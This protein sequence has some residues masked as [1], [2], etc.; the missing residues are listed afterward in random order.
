M[1]LYPSWMLEAVLR[2]I[3]Q[4]ER[5]HVVAFLH[6]AECLCCRRDVDPLRSYSVLLRRSIVLIFRVLCFRFLSLNA[7]L[8]ARICVGTV[9]LALARTRLGIF[10]E[11]QVRGEVRRLILFL[12]MS[13][14]GLR[15]L[16]LYKLATEPGGRHR[17]VPGTVR[18]PL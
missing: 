14:T 9:R 1:R 8:L 18:R 6:L 13:M 7:T 2:Q 15:R 17:R 5:W 3:R 10:E 12:A 16:W 4:Q 11:V